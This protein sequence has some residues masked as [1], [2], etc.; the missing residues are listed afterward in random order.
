MDKKRPLYI[1]FI[2][3]VTQF[4]IRGRLYGG[5]QS[6]YLGQVLKQEKEFGTS[7]G[8]SDE[9]KDVD[10]EMFVG[11][12]KITTES[13]YI[14]AVSLFDAFIED[15]YKMLVG[16]YPE[17]VKE[18]LVADYDLIFECQT[19]DNVREE[20]LGRAAKEFSFNS[21]KDRVR[22]ITKRFGLQS[23]P[24]DLTKN[25]HDIY[26]KRHGIVHGLSQSKHISVNNDSLLLPPQQESVFK[27]LVT[28]GDCVSAQQT[29]NKVA[30]FISMSIYN[31]VLTNYDDKYKVLLKAIQRIC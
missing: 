23:I 19:I 1:S 12:R 16:F 13:Y 15:T 27:Q 7:Q 3:V 10:R 25:I 29:F 30:K 26:E 6:V 5:A 2:T 17:V 8:K 31:K 14:Y 4:W 28:D 9:L 21:I 22:F 20:V 24:H 18:K 11:F